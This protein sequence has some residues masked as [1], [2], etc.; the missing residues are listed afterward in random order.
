MAAET[1][2][3]HWETSCL[4]LVSIGVL[5]TARYR[6]SVG[7][8]LRRCALGVLLPAIGCTVHNVPVSSPLNQPA[9]THRHLPQAETS[10]L[11][12][13]HTE[14]GKTVSRFMVA[15]NDDTDS[16]IPD[17]SSWQFAGLNSTSGWAT[18]PDGRNWTRQQQV[19]AT[20]ALQ[21]RGV[22]ALHGDPW[23]AGWNSTDPKVPSGV[24]YISVAQNGLKRW[25]PPWFLVAARSLDSGA[26]FQDPVVILGPQPSLAD[27]PKIAVTGDGRF[28]I[29]AWIGPTMQFK[30][31]SDTQDPNGMTIPSDQNGVHDIQPLDIASPPGKNCTYQAIPILH[32]QVAAS[33]QT[34]YLAA[35]VLYQGGGQGCP[36][37]SRIEVYRAN[38]PAL[39]ANQTVFSR[40]LSVR[41]PEGADDLAAQNLQG[42]TFAHDFDRGGEGK[43]LA[44]GNDAGGDYVLLVTQRTLTVQGENSHNE[45]VQFR[46]AGAD[47]CD[48]ANHIG[49]L[50]TCGS[51][52][53][54][55][56]VI[57]ARA[58]L[59]Y[60]ELKPQVFVGKVPDGGAKDLRAG[61]VWYTQP[62]RGQQGMAITDEMRARTRMEAAI[63]I[64]GGV[65]YSGPFGL[66]TKENGPGPPTDPA[67]GDYFIP[68]QFEGDPAGY[69][70]EYIGGAFLDTH[71]IYVTAT[72]A[73][74]REGCMSQSSPGTF[75]MHVWSG[76]LEPEKFAVTNACG[77]TSA[78]T[79]P[80]GAPCEESGQCGRWSCLGGNA[81]TCDTNKGIRNQC[82]GCTPLPIGGTGHGL[83]DFCIC[84]NVARSE[85]YLVC[86][87]KKD[88]LI[89][90]PC[91]SA[92]GCG[93]GPP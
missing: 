14:N 93:P 90:C 56:Q 85:G 16:A 71:S 38:A 50:D 36:N 42:G 60:Y 30:V 31:L 37:A 44:I 6:L 19:I 87:P 5:R 43:S 40:V 76:W 32:P 88:T 49:D 72:W 74:S 51:F 28:A 47:S 18:S 29:A 12:V 9:A 62:Y 11:R 39:A 46:L 68:C 73:D 77:G 27:G 34:F 84:N 25:G 48:A 69:F 20:P 13:D 7:A 75:H 8:L 26:S 52:D 45:V 92:P 89:C 1:P 53:M 55:P 59:G 67:I 80:P 79:H 86:G 78:L 82:G 24:L 35:H 41:E 63:S 3:I 4:A 70:G 64:D 57:D 91:D 54:Q 23:L 15:Y 2:G 10:M 61:I 66:L 58:R 17:G 83:G 33:Q 21:A 22:N 65:S 81:V